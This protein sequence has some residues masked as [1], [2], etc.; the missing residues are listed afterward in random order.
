MAYCALETWREGCRQS[1]LGDFVVFESGFDVRPCNRGSCGVAIVL[2]PDGVHGHAL[3]KALR[4]TAAQRRC[5][6]PALMELVERI[7]DDRHGC[8]P[9]W[10][11]LAMDRALWR[12]FVQGTG[13]FERVQAET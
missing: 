12:G 5:A 1:N 2:D 11:A 6:D 13:P 8:L 9:I 3:V 7:R 4:H 10:G